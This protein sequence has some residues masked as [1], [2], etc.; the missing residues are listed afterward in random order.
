L[1]EIPHYGAE[2]GTLCM[3]R[4][5]EE[6]DGQDGWTSVVTFREC[7]FTMIRG[8]FSVQDGGFFTSLLFSSNFMGVSILA[9][10]KGFASG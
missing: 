7:C 1:L 8:V 10:R 3:C 5:E 2:A 6:K 4:R 9:K